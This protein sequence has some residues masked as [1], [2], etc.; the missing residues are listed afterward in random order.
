LFASSLDVSQGALRFCLRLLQ[1]FLGAL[2]ILLGPLAFGVRALSVFLD[3]V[4]LAVCTLQRFLPALMIRLHALEILLGPLAVGLRALQFFLYPVAL[5]LCTLQLVVCSLTIGLGP[6]AIRVRAFEI[7]LCAL[8][9]RLRPLAFGVRA[10]EIRVRATALGR[11]C[12]VEFMPCLRGGVRCCLLGLTA[13]PRYLSKRALHLR[14]RRRDFGCE[15]RIPLRVNGVELRRPPLFRV[16]LGALTGV[17]DGLFVAVRQMA[18][19]GVELGL[20]FRSNGVD[21]AAYRFLGHYLA[22]SGRGSGKSS[23]E[24]AA[25]LRVRVS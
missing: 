23:S 17:I 20:K 12:F 10:F 4:A 18:Q 8:K 22:L 9:I 15:T 3:A 13:R 14:A 25:T 11:D 16:R 5:F 19:V 2:Q 24:N 7:G 21:H 1:R 6:V